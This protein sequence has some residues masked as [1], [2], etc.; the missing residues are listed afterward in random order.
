[1]LPFACQYI[2]SLM[3]F[4][5]YNLK[6]FPTTAYVHNLDTRNKNKLRLPAVS[7]ASV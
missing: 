7:L 1:M 6:D 4:V 2:L 3:L 5:I